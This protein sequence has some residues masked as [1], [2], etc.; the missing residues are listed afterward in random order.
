M[1]SLP[2]IHHAIHE[3]HSLRQARLNYSTM[4]VGTCY[5]IVMCEL[6]PHA[7][8]LIGPETLNPEL[9][10]PESSA[11]SLNDCPL[12]TKKRTFPMLEQIV[13]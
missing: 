4:Y 11:L 10:E 7:M 12:V 5:T 13:P 8:K 1:Y 9:L 2:L 3:S 6:L